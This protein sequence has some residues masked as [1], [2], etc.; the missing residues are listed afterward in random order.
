VLRNTTSFVKIADGNNFSVPTEFAIRQVLSAVR[1]PE[2]AELNA[3]AAW[4]DHRRGFGILHLIDGYAVQITM[5]SA[6]Q[7]R[8]GHD[9]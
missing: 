4:G 7:V 9:G 3:A 8:S 2:H 6:T 5:W 1:I